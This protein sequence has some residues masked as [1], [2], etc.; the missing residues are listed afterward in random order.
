MVDTPPLLDKTQLVS[1]M[2][3]GN[4]QSILVEESK[5][6]KCH[7]ALESYISFVSCIYIYIYDIYVHL[8]YI[9]EQHINAK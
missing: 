3:C 8:V 4:T 5:N 7:D 6:V 1:G 9:C 2:Y